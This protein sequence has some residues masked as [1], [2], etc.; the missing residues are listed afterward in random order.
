M[1]LARRILRF[2]DISDTSFQNT[3]ALMDLQGSLIGQD[4]PI[5]PRVKEILGLR[6]TSSVYYANRYGWDFHGDYIE[7]LV[8]YAKWCW[9]DALILQ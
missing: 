5:Y 6:N 1:E 7:F 2:M 3:D 9:K 4:I 8:E